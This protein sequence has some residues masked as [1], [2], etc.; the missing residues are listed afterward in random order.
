MWRAVWCVTAAI[1]QHMFSTMP[2]AKTMLY[3][4][5]HQIAASRGAGMAGLNEQAKLSPT[6]RALIDVVNSDYDPR[7]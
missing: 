6:I 1:G 2:S 3:V 4:Y 7:R 5:Q